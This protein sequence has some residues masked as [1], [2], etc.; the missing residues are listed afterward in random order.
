MTATPPTFAAQPR[1]RF[2]KMHGIGNDYVYA[3][4]TAEAADGPALA[5]RPDLPAIARAIADRHTGVGSDGLIL[6]CTPTPTGAAAG[7]LVRMR[8]FN[9][10]GS[11]SPMCGNG[12]RC[13]AKFAHDRLGLDHNPLPIETGRGILHVAPLLEG[14]R[15][16]GATVDMGAP[17]LTPALVPSKLAANHPSGATVDAPFDLRGLPNR[18]EARATTVSMGNPHAVFFVAD[19]HALDLRTLGPAVENHPAFPRRTNAHFVAVHSRDR[20]TMRTWERGS[21]VTL[22]CGTGACAVLV[23]GVLS[24]RLDRRALVTLPGGDLAVRW[25]EATNHVFMTGPAADVFE[26]TWLLPTAP[27][28]PAGPA[29]SPAPATLTTARLLLRTFT[30]EDAPQVSTLAGAPEIASTTL[31]IPHPYHEHHARRW[32]ASLTP[33]HRE[34]PAHVFALTLRDTG[35]LVGAMGLHIDPRHNAAEVGYW[36]AVP[37]WSRGFATEALAAVLNFG[38]RTLGLHRIHAH[39][40]ARN[41]ASGRVM[42]KCGMKPEGTLRGVPKKHGRYEDSVV[43]ALL[44]DEFLSCRSSPGAPR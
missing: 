9:A 29:P 35:E 42:L 31:L 32:I 23:A 13:V 7:A 44:R 19:P 34:T 3:D 14:G 37:H 10:D 1:L 17:I 33:E 5:D 39:H 8:M 16:V 24:G 28:Q 6:L 2:V 38:F 22:A 27:D 11:E 4:A 18:L 21:G 26:G 36:V 15:F 12:I 41:P 43:Y 40:F 30:L 25:D 20:A